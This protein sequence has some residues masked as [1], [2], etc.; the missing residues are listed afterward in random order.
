MNTVRLIDG[1]EVSSSS[2]EWRQEC[3]ERYLHV[4]NLMRLGS[5]QERAQYLETVRI[6]SGDEA[7]RRLREAFLAEWQRRRGGSNQDGAS[8]HA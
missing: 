8:C 6:T 2:E 3:L 1:R 5:R 4:C 7:E